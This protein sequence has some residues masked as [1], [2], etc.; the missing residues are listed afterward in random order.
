MIT[1]VLLVAQHTGL[2]FLVGIYDQA[3]REAGIT[4]TDDRMKERLVFMRR[5][6][7][8]RA[9]GHVVHRRLKRQAPSL[10]CFAMVAGNGSSGR[11]AG[12]SMVL[13]PS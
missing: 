8:Q 7:L 5:T 2:I 12:V 9:A 10:Y 4:S 13:R 1:N 6:K 11:L 3:R